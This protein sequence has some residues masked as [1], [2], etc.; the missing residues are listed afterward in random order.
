VAV[1]LGR[2]IFLGEQVEKRGK[3]RFRR[4]PTFPDMGAKKGGSACFDKF[5]FCQKQKKYPKL[6]K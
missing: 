3:W 2:L 4:L 5:Q 6:E 1:L